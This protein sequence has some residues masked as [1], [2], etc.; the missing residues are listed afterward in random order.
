MRPTENSIDRPRRGGMTRVKRMIPAPTA[1]M[2][3]VWPMPQ[4]APMMAAPPS[5]FAGDDGG[6]GDDV[7]GVGGVAHAQEEAEGEDSDQAYR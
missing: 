7:V 6:D 1:R 2:V 4:S 3:M 5:R